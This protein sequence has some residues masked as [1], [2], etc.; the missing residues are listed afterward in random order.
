MGDS[1]AVKTFSSRLSNQNVHFYVLK[2]KES[3][4]LWIGTDASFRTLAIAMNSRL[5]PE[6][7]CTQL[8]GAS[9]DNAA[10]NLAQKLVKRF[11]RHCF[12]S[13]NVQD[14]TLHPMIEDYVS[15]MLDKEPQNFFF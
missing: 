9:T 2:L 10:G 15:K 8:L 14:A 4:L 1:V 5:D 11:G 6:P 12:V 13:M 7:I 3:Y